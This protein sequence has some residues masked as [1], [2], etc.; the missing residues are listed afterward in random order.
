MH[1]PIYYQIAV[2][3][4]II[5]VVGGTMYA[6]L[7][8]HRRH[9]TLPVIRRAADARGAYVV[10]QWGRRTYMSRDGY[11]WQNERNKRVSTR[12]SARLRQFIETYGWTNV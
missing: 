10:L 2:A 4:F 3:Y 9:R 12:K 8:Y 11:V 7:R 6:W 1:I 5:S